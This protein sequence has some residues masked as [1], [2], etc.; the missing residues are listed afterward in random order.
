MSRPWYDSLPYVIV[1]FA[2]DLAT[3]SARVFSF[4]ERAARSCSAGSSRAA[5]ALRE[6]LG[7]KDEDSFQ[8]ARLRGEV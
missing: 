1:D 7:R 4:T 5:D 3:I 2:R 6:S 8:A